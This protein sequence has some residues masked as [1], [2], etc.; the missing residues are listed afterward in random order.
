MN[1]MHVIYRVKS[2]L[3]TIAEYERFRGN[4]CCATVVKIIAGMSHPA[5]Q[6]ES[7]SHWT[8][9][10]IPKEH[11]MEEVLIACYLLN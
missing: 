1:L 4:H 2:Q 3:N 5:Q 9:R 10:N 8:S 6:H 11:A 7:I